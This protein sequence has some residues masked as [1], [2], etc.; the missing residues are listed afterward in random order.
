M[1]GSPADV[2]GAAGLMSTGRIMQPVTGEPAALS[3]TVSTPLLIRVGMLRRVRRAGSRAVSDLEPPAGELPESCPHPRSRGQSNVGATGLGGGGHRARG[4]HFPDPPA[5]R[6]RDTVG[7]PARRKAAAWS[8]GGRCSCFLLLLVLLP[9]GAGARWRANDRCHVHDRSTGC[10]RKSPLPSSGP[11]QRSPPALAAPLLRQFGYPIGGFSLAT[12]VLPVRVLMLVGAF[13]LLR[14]VTRR[15]RTDDAVFVL[16]CII[17]A[18]YWA[19]GYA[20]LQ[21]EW[22]PPTRAPR[23]CCRPGTRPGGSRSCNLNRLPRCARRYEHRSITT[24]QIVTQWGTVFGDEVATAI[25]DRLLPP[26]QSHADDL[27]REHSI[28]T[29]K[30]GYRR[31]RGHKTRPPLPGKPHRT[32]FPSRPQPCLHP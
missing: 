2:D 24:H 7:G 20:K 27:R 12:S 18:H 30:P 1:I 14:A 19:S 4:G 26:S 11:S 28:A 32:R 17:A 13:W 25:L 10:I 15:G 16:C 3:R 8:G 22:P 6:A 29:K 31:C 5:A 23:C 21:L 9:S